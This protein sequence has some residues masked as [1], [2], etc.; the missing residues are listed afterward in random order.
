MTAPISERRTGRTAGRISANRVA[1]L[2]LPAALAAGMLAAMAGLSSLGLDAFSIPFA[3]TAAVLAMA[4]ASPIARPRAVIVAY[5]MSTVPALTVVAL[6]PAS[7]VTATVT[8][9]VAI[10]G[11]LLMRAVHPPAAAGAVMI[12]LHDGDWMFLLDGV[13]PALGAVLAI[14]LAA[15]AVIP[16]YGYSWRSR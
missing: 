4:P 10:V 14:A 12:G 2:L 5:A 1:E 7:V 11:M 16:R 8:G 13:V 3:A 15:G 9:C 6:V